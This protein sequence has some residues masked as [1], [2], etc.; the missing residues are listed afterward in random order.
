[1]KFLNLIFL[2]T[3]LISLL[4]I[5]TLSTIP[6]QDV[7]FPGHFDYEDKANSDPPQQTISSLRGTSRFL[8]QSQSFMTCDKNPRVC[9]AQGNPGPDC[10]KKM[11]VNKTTDKFNC[12]KYGKKCRYTGICCGG[13]YVN[14]MYSKKHCGGCNNKCKKM[15]ACQYGMCS[16]A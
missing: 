10:C 7:S 8:A 12:G 14:P 4:S 5:T 3:M 9:R 2:P 1:M 6:T 13:Q 15:S 16:Y 11:C